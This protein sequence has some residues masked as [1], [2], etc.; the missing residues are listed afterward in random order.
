MPTLF[1]DAKV[2]RTVDRS[3]FLALM[4][5]GWRLNRYV[6]RRQVSNKAPSD[7]RHG[8]QKLPF[9][10]PGGNKTVYTGGT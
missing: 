3:R 9:S 1:P 4:A 2:L 10:P 7:S 6:L 8:N 5:S